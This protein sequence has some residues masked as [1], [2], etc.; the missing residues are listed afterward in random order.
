MHSLQK[1]AFNY[2]KIY[3]PLTTSSVLE[4]SRMINLA[5]TFDH[6]LQEESN[7]DQEVVDED[8]SQVITTMMRRSGR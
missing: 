2:P 3:F 8:A 1:P 4:P 6:F 7:D 5:F